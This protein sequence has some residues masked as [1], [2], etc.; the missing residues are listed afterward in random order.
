MKK[1]PDLKGKIFVISAPSGC[2][3][4]TLANK[5]LDDKLGL[6]VS[7]SATTRGPRPGEIDGEH[8]FFVTKEKF[9][10]MAS[11]GEFLEHEENFG[12]F[13]GTPKKPIEKALRKGISVLLNI[14]VKGAMRVRRAHPFD[15]VLIFIMPPS[16][17]V[18]K[19]RLHGRKADKTDEIKRRLDLA[20]IEMSYRNKYD[21]TI[22]NDRLD[23]AY[24]KL[25]KIVIDENNK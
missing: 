3:K 25:K 10:K 4:T 16:I 18:L 20:K 14:D 15:S 11:N 21:H 19:K 17:T 2:G 13:Y 5:L 23:N 7:I 1:A 6:A 8:Y 9:K 12:N 24:K 22:V